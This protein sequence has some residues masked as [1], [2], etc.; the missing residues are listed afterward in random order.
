MGADKNDTPKEDTT[1][2]GILIHEEDGRWTVR[3]MNGSCCHAVRS[4]RREAEARAAELGITIV[5]FVDLTPI[6]TP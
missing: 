3:G 5:N 1:M 4:S 6:D 2:N